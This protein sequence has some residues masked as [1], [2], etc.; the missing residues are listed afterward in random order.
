MK[1]T[2]S[3]ICI[4]VLMTVAPALAAPDLSVTDIH[5]NFGDDRSDSIVRVYVNCDN[6]I[7]A[8]VQNAGPDAVTDD[9]EVCFAADGAVIGCANVTGGLAADANTTVSIDWTP[10]CAEYYV[11]PGFPSQSLPLTIT[12]TADCNCSSCPNCPDDGSCGTVDETNETDNTLS[13]VIPAIQDYPAT[14]GVIGGVVNNGYM[15]KNFDC[16]TT[17]EPLYLAGY[18]D[19]VGGGVEYNVSGAR[20]STF[21]TQET[22]T[23]VHHIDL[24]D[25]A[26]VIDARLYVHWYDKWGNYET[27]PTGCLANLS[28]NFSGTDLMPDAA[29]QD[30]KAFG[31]YQSPKGSSVFDVTSLVSGSGDYTAIVK[32]IEPIG[33]N[34]TTL[35]GEMLVVVYDGADHG[36]EVQIWMLEGTDYLMAADETH[37]GNNYSVSPEKATATVALPGAI[38]LTDVVDAELITFVAQGMGPGSDLLFNGEV[39]KTDAWNTSTEAYPGSKINVEDVS[40]LSKLFS[41]ENTMGFRDNGSTG[42]QAA[43]AALMIVHDELTPG[44]VNGDGVLTTTDSVLALQIA[45][46]GE[47]SGVADING[48][49]AVT[50]ID[51]LMILQ[52]IVGNIEL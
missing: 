12:A 37:G 34:N 16:D 27:Y 51:A 26:V 21:A 20:I 7:S 52:A 22:D 48:D 11:M 40:V 23:R 30:S 6:V 44:D 42:M 24:P 49:D 10:T 36:D 1:R 46:R 33:G 43:C 9:F 39:I 50:S 14:N 8:V 3:L 28:M 4:A 18:F 2:I 17:E 29:Y 35:L 47:Y 31:Y 41:S 25:G 19:T 15:S 13:L 32:N 5:V 38:D 45:V